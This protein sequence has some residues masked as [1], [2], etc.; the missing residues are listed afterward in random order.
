MTLAG[1]EYY[2]FSRF[3]LRNSS[4]KDKYPKVIE[5]LLKD[6]EELLEFY[7]YPAAHWQ[8]LRTTN[9]IESTFATI[10][11][12]T[13][14]SKGCLNK[15]TM[16]NMVFKLGL[17]AQSKWRRMRGFRELDKVIRGVKFQNGIEI[18]NTKTNQVA[19]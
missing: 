7:D 15:V 13:K 1:L 4:Y 9:P 19:A 2:D 11:H 6:S 17:C 5:I 14:R 18:I 16:L 12:R 10:R 3:E 8:S